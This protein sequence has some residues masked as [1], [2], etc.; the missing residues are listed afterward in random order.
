[1]YGLGEGIVSGAITPDHYKIDRETYEVSFKYQAPKNIMYCKDGVCGII[2]VEVPPQLMTV[3][4]LDE[5]DLKQL[6]DL[7]NKVETHFGSPQDIEWGAEGRQI[8]LL[9]SRPI[10]TL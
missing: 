9:Q 4:V 5:E 1:M 10:T 2:T 3:P 6:V 8:F 7:A